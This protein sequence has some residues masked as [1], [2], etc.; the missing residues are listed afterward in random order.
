MSA[1][2]PGL[3]K[4][5]SNMVLRSDRRTA[6]ELEKAMPPNDAGSV[7]VVRYSERRPPALLEGVN[8]VMEALDL[9]LQKISHDTSKTLGTLGLL[10]SWAF[11][12]NAGISKRQNRRAA[13]QGGERMI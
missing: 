8:G 7:A 13:W 3:R 2:P 4:S 12:P 10:P 1:L 5:S 9:S 11:N 6:Q